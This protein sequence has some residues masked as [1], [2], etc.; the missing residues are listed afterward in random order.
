VGEFAISRSFIFAVGGNAANSENNMSTKICRF[1]VWTLHQRPRAVE[2]FIADGA[3][4]NAD[5]DAAE[6]LNFYLRMPLA[7]A[8]EQNYPKVSVNRTWIAVVCN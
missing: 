5:P 4:L 3:A 7:M 6:K 2:A 1:T 8:N